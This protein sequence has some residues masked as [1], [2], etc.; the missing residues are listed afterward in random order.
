[1]CR[2]S[3]LYIC[4]QL[5]RRTGLS[6]WVLQSTITPSSDADANKPSAQQARQQMPRPTRPGVRCVDRASWIASLL[7]VHYLR[8]RVPML[9][10]VCACVCALGRVGSVPATW[11]RQRTA[12]RWMRSG[13][14]TDDS[15]LCSAS[16]PTLYTTAAAPA[17]VPRACLHRHAGT[18]ACVSV[19]V[20]RG[21][22]RRDDAD[23][24]TRR[25][26]RIS[27]RLS[28]SAYAHPYNQ[29]RSRKCRGMWSS[30]RAYTTGVIDGLPADDVCAPLATC[31]CVCVYRPVCTDK[32]TLCILPGNLA[33]QRAVRAAPHEQP[34]VIAA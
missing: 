10:S 24:A 28:R 19:C 21:G 9:D 29:S 8:T 33:L 1:M 32:R 30:K 4:C 20:N 7:I 34:V 16:V 14:A 12:S 31:A 6:V 3:S 27:S 2:C 5:R 25:L 18:R 15:V 22:V 17:L 23:E 13:V 11:A 26:F